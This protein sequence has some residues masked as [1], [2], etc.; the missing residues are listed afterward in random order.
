MTAADRDESVRR[1]VV[2]RILRGRLEDSVGLRNPDLTEQELKA[3]NERLQEIWSA[4]ESMRI[5]W[6][7]LNTH[8]TPPEALLERFCTEMELPLSILDGI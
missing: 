4:F 3:A 7:Y 2:I 6:D 1:L 8:E 5:G